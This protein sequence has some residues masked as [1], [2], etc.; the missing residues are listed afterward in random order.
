MEKRL[1]FR[2][3]IAKN[4]RNSFFLLLGIVIIFIL[5]GYI[6]AQAIS[7]ERIFF[8]LI[9]SIII[10]ISYV[11]IGYYN[12]DKIAL[13]SV[14]AKPAP[15][16]KYPLYHDVVE[17]MCL[18][19]GLPKP[20]L[21]VMDSE[22]IN[23]FATGRNPENSAICVTTGAIKK[24]DR[25]EL[26]GVIAHEMSHI[27]NYDIRYMTLTTTL[28]GMLAIFS[29]LFLR[30]LWFGNRD[31]DGRQALFLILGIILAII[32]PI[33]VYLIQM[34]ISRKREFA[35]DASAVKFTR[36]PPGLIKA[37]EKIKK[38]T[39][40]KKKEIPKAIAPLFF[41][42]PFGKLDS[43]HPPIEERIKRLRRM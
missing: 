27:A 43:T 21:Y 13:S 7:P 8:I 1:D 42:N 34:A 26:E 25:R 35:A 23:A 2:D 18:A 30:S 20:K 19:S 5:L 39:S 4:K 41:T 36:Y 28:V 38:E 40:S 3:Q 9:L 11:L 14:K 37:L 29:E 24:L 10:S 16:E 17:G 22:D 33:I 31:R 32:S 6:I 12:S 15:R